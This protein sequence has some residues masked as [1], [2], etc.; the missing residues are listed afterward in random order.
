MFNS[1]SVTVNDWAQGDPCTATIS[2]VL[3]DPI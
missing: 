1:V 3:C 2:D